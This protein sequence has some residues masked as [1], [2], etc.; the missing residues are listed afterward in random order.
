MI[1]VSAGVCMIEN[2][3]NP[4]AYG[5]SSNNIPTHCYVHRQMR[6]LMLFINRVSIQ[7]AIHIQCT[8]HLEIM[9]V[10]F[11]RSIKM[12]KWFIF[13]CILAH[14]VVWTSGSRRQH[15]KWY[16]SIVTQIR[17]WDQK[18][19]KIMWKNSSKIIF[20]YSF[21]SWSIHLIHRINRS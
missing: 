9:S 11:V 15:Q 19:K 1:N 5:E 13:K 4:A 18:Q 6:C 14:H 8:M 16:V 21:H 10:D 20:R 7:N 2:C 17:N 12:T 3:T